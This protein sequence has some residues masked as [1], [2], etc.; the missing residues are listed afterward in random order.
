MKKYRELNAKSRKTTLKTDTH[1]TKSNKSNILFKI[2]IILFLIISCIVLYFHPTKE[3]LHCNNNLTCKVERTYFGVFKTYKKIKLKPT[4][5]LTCHIGAYSCTKTSTNYGLYLRIDG[6]APFVFYVSNSSYRNFDDQKKE[7]N[8]DC[9]DY[10]QNFRKYINNYPEYQFKIESKADTI[11][12]II[13]IIIIAT[14]FFCIFYE[15]IF[16]KTK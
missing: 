5:N 16:K 11:D 10:Y 14:I 15:P 7:L 12:L 13:S 6:I 2:G 1:N 8:R 4:S 3:V 9:N